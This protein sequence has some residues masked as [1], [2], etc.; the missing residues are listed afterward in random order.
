MSQMTP[1]EVRDV[2]EMFEATR[3]AALEGQH[4]PVPVESVEVVVAEPSVPEQPTGDD[5]IVPW[6]SMALTAVA[7]A[8]LTMVALVV[9]YPLLAAGCAFVML[10]LGSLL[11]CAQVFSLRARNRRVA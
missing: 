6:A 9:P 2:T 7:I 1:D 8:L 11:I 4:L 5:P 3:L 10:I